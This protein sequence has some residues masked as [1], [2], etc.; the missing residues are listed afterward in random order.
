M[1]AIINDKA[2]MVRAF[3]HVDRTA[4]VPI[5]VLDLEF[6]AVSI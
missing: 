3:V 4:V 1:A 6:V 2:D 5:K